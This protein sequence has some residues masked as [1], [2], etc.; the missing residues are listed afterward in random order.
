MKIFLKNMCNKDKERKKT[1]TDEKWKLF[2]KKGK[3]TELCMEKRKEAEKRKKWC[4]KG[5]L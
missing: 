3:G 1:R 2:A 5:K 4:M